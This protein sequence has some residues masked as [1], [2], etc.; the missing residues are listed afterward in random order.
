MI[1]KEISLIRENFTLK[2]AKIIFELNH[3]V[4]EL[5][6]LF[7]NQRDRSIFFKNC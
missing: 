6:E 5:I 2:F 4:I 3:S 7:G 1:K